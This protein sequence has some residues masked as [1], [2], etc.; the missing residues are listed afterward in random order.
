MQDIVGAGSGRPGEIYVRGVGT[1]DVASWDDDMIYD[2]VDVDANTGAGSELVF[3]RDI[4][5]KTYRQTNMSL[6]S[7][8]PTGW[9][10]IGL[11]VGCYV[12]PETAALD[13]DPAAHRATAANIRNVI[14]YGYAELELD[15]RL[16]VKHGPIWTFQ[17][18][19]GIWGTDDASAAGLFSNGVPSPVAVPILSIPIY[20]TDQQT[21]RGSV[22]FY[23][24]PGL[25]GDEKVSITMFIYGFVKRPAQ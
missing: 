10:I 23:T 7:Q 22:R 11:K 19:Y 2:T 6:S 9:Q 24:T 18:G 1:I 17:P 12:S 5:N 25:S 20:I 14:R 21:I 16:I 15:G 4:S 3:F 13:A 8:L